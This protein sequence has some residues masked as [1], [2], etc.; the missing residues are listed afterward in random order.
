MFSGASLSRE[1]TNCNKKH[2]IYLVSDGDVGALPAVLP[3]SLHAVLTDGLIVD[4]NSLWQPAV[5][6]NDLRGQRLTK[7]EQSHNHHR[8][9]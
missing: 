3:C 1:Q 6:Q 8:L 4:G 7:Q 2:R 5:F 9:Y